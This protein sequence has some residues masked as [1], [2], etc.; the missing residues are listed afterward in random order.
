MTMRGP[1][2]ADLQTTLRRQV[3]HLATRVKPYTPA[4]WAASSARPGMTNADVTAELIGVLAGFAHG[5]EHRKE[6]TPPTFPPPGRPVDLVLGMVLGTVGE[7]LFDLLSEVEATDAVW[8]PGQRLSV[9]TV[10][11]LGLA[12]AVLHRWDVTGPGDRG[13]EPRASRLVLQG[14]FPS[15]DDSGASPTALLLHLTGR[16][17]LDGRPGWG[18][19]GWSWELPEG[20]AAGHASG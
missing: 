5:A 4:D 13:P 19:D 7:R 14:L 17:Q 9:R 18:G 12:E 10:S 20:S 1:T 8:V 3:E 2:A 16:R 6:P 15:Q 11:A